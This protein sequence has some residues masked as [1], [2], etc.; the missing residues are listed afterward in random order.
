MPVSL[1]VPNAG[2][3]R[4]IWTLPGAGGMINVLGINLSTAAAI[5]QTVVNTLGALIKGHFTSTGWAGRIHTSVTLANVGVRDIRTAHRAEFIDAGAA[6]PG[7]GTGDALPR[8]NALVVSLRTALAGPS[9]RGRVYLGGFSETDNEADATATGALVT[10]AVSFV[11]SIQ[12]DLKAA[13][14]DLAVISRPGLEKTVTTVTVLPG[15]VTETNTHHTIARA[16][17]MNPVIGIIGRN[18]IWDS[19]RRRSAPGSVSTFM[20]PLVAF[21]AQTGETTLSGK[22]AV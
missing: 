4:L 15:G 2:L 6:V 22:A 18:D 21:S 8:G 19:Q 16:G 10:T 3:L 17:D 9:F 14:W 13:G 5:D 1:V 12:N 11:T 7:T 20:A